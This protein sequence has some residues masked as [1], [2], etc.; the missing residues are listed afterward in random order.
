MNEELYNELKE[1]EDRLY[2]IMVVLDRRATS[3]LSDS[4]SLLYDYLR[5]NKPE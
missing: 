3:K 1:I 5:E 2:D 4:W